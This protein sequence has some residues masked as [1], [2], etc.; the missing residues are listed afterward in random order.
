[1]YVVQGDCRLGTPGCRVL[2]DRQPYGS[3]LVDALSEGIAVES[4]L[5]AQTL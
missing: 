3:K 2:L 1:M 5:G 4:N